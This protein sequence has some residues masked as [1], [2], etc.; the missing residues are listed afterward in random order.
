MVSGQR[1]TGLFWLTI[2]PLFV[3]PELVL[4]RIWALPDRSLVA[5][6]DSE[7]YLRTPGR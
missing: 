6:A 1:R 3:E 7:N 4:G 5:L 2:T